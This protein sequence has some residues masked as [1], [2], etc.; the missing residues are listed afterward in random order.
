MPRLT[1]AVPYSPV[2]LQTIFVNANYENSTF[3]L[4]ND[5]TNWSWGGNSSGKLGL[6]DSAN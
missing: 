1:F 2:P 6:G 5:S 3:A 4:R